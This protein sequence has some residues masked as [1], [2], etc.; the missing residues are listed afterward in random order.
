MRHTCVVFRVSV[1]RIPKLHNFDDRKKFKLSKTKILWVVTSCISKRAPSFFE[2]EGELL[3]RPQMDKKRIT[4]NIRTFIFLYIPS[5]NTDTLVSSLYLCVETRNIEVFLLLS[6][7]FPT[8][9][10]TS[11][12]S[13]K[14]LPPSCQPLYATNTSHR[15]QAIFLY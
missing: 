12:S 3:N 11:S 4:C 9:V 2:H 5:T 15:K 10:S 14:R 7:H 6:Q 8:S 13:A 1:L